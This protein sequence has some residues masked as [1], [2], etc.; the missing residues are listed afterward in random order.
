MV[1]TTHCENKR[2]HYSAAN[3]RAPSQPWHLPN[4]LVDN[5]FGTFEVVPMGSAKHTVKMEQKIFHKTAT[6]VEQKPGFW[7]K[8]KLTC[9]YILYC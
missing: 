9:R 7:N 2:Y 3:R 4:S 5:S 8:C 1:D 6:L